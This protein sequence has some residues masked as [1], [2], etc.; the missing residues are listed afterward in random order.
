MGLSFLDQAK[1]VDARHAR[2]ERTD[3]NV[4]PLS[5]FATEAG[6]TAPHMDA[7]TGLDDIEAR[8]VGWARSYT[9]A[10]KLAELSTGT[11]RLGWLDQAE[12]ALGHL[13]RIVGAER[14]A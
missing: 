8:I 3:S 11:V 5:V 14:A 7:C 2:G 9:A 10:R 1:A 6:R 4:I 12:M 13:R